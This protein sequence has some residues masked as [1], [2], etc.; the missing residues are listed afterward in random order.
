MTLS[1]YWSADIICNLLEGKTVRVSV[2]QLPF[3]KTQLYF[4]ERIYTYLIIS[5]PSQNKLVVGSWLMKN[6]SDFWF[7]GE[8]S[9]NEMNA[10]FKQLLVT[11]RN[12]WI[13][14]ENLKDYLLPSLPATLQPLHV[15]IM[16]PTSCCSHFIEK[17]NSGAMHI[18]MLTLQENSPSNNFQTNCK[19]HHP[20]LCQRKY[21]VPICM[22]I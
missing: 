3:W 12:G 8:L 13:G 15:N 6:W 5:F 22:T 4:A 10:S 2:S 14:W 21:I 18:Y 11:L 16:T 19:L 1:R 7:E 17:E 20:L 9:S